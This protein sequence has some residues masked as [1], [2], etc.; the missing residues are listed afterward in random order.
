MRPFR[1]S[2]PRRPG[3]ALQP[4]RRQ[5]EDSGMA[6]SLLYLE[7]L[8]DLTHGLT[9]NRLRRILRDADAGIISEQHALFANME[10]RCDHLAA[11]MGK[12]KRSLLTLEWDILPAVKDDAKAREAARQVRAMVDALPSVDDIILDMA[13]AIGHGFSALEIEWQ[14]AD[15]WHIPKAV[16]FRPQSWFVCP[17][18]DR[19][20]LHLR[21][22]SAEGAE[23][24]PCGWIV[25]THK[26]R[27]GWLPRAGLFRVLAWTYLIRAY[28]ASSEVQYVQ[29]HGLPLRLGKY[30][31]GSTKEDKTALLNALRCLG[32]DAAGIIP[33]GM[34][35]LFESPTA[36]TRDIPGE[37]VTR[38]EQG[39]SKA[40]LGGTLTSQADGKTSTNALGEIH[41]Q[42]RRDILSA[43]ARQIAATLTEQLL[44]P[45]AML[46]LGITDRRAL[47][48]W[49]FDTQDAADLALYA[50]ALPKLAP[51][52][53]I[54][55]RYVHE[56]LKLPE[57]VGEEDV[58]QAATTPP[59]P[60]GEGEPQEENEGTSAN[61]AAKAQD[62]GGAAQP[63]AAGAAKALDTINADAA[64]T[65]AGESL[66]RPL[67]DDLAKGVTPE[68]LQARLAEL[69]PRMDTD[70]LADILAR[71][72]FVAEIWGRVSANA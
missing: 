67:L 53:R 57:A 52:M 27:S 51:Y 7:Q 49:Q 12:R 23:L 55:R 29:I 3:A 14:Y 18:R 70:E 31:P 13:D 41:E 15:G 32:Q 25:H 47:P 35:V 19:N 39:M 37:L 65:A 69:Y 43:D 9:P 11:E 71:A 10:E 33:V 62:A 54:S 60:D 22:G 42:V 44:R 48:W 21:D 8:P 17:W 46:N 63:S 24:W 40:I 26:S 34:E 72:M 1:R 4:G 56:R 68:E 58:F 5:T 50:D 36:N 30:P 66:L 28:A 16:T 59:E 6:A 38:C 64:L 45:L 20:V 61:A 2:L